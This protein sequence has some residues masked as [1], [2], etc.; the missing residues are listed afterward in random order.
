MPLVYWYKD[1]E[2]KEPVYYD[3]DDLSNKQY[4]EV[5]R[6][7]E[8]MHTT[9]KGYFKIKAQRDAIIWRALHGS[10]D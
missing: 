10:E 6:L 9:N 8:Q 5:C 3:T 7:E 4:A 1:E 2:T